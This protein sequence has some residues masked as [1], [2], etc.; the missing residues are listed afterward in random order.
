MLPIKEQTLDLSNT[1]DTI[2]VDYTTNENGN[3]NGNDKLRED[4]T[5]EYSPNNDEQPVNCVQQ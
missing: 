3:D 1:V 2:V 4:T 5:N